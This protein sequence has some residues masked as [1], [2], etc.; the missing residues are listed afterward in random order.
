MFA[1]FIL[2]S[3]YFR[4]AD[5]VDDTSYLEEA[6]RDIVGNL[7]LLTD[8]GRSGLCEVRLTPDDKFTSIAV[9][10]IR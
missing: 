1:T 6:L 5:T 8:V 4:P 2:Q 9:A 10:E 7:R 3:L